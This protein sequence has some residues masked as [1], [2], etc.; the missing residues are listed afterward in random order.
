MKHAT[1]LSAGTPLLV[2][3]AAVFAVGDLN[4]PAGSVT[5]TGKRLTELEPRIAIS[6]TNTPGDGISLFRI[7]QPGS[8]YLTGNVTGEPAKHGITVLATGVTIDLNGFDLAGVAG[9]F[10]GITT[11]GVQRNLTVRNG[12]VR[13]WGQTGVNLSNSASGLLVQGIR[14]QGNG[15]DGIA[16]VYQAVIADCVST[17]NGRDGITGFEDVVFKDCVASLNTTRG[18]SVTNHGHFSDCVSEE[19]G[20]DG[21]GIGN[22][23]RIVDCIANTN[24]GDGIEG[25]TDNYLSANTLDGNGAATG[26]GAGILLTSIDNRVEGNNCTDNDRGVDVN[27]GG[28]FIVRNTCTGNTTNW[29]IVANN[30]CGPI[31]DR[32][33]PASAAILGNSGASSLGSTEPNANFTY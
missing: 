22:G 3:A 1:L 32:T 24:T 31:V 27:A 15:L 6:A 30:V 23:S 5:A 2:A 8:Y 17:L 16:V 18:F 20:T 10:S 28:N 4:P 21:F 9:S 26:D 12:T 25:G 7:T 13:G 11:S 14:A 33:A 19:N 29:D